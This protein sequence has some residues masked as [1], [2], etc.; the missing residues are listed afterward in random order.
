MSGDLIPI[1]LLAAGASRR[2]GRPKALLPWGKQTLIEYQAARLSALG[3]PVVVVLGCHAGKILPYLRT[4]NVDP[5]P[6]DDWE[7]GMGHSIAHGMKHITLH[8]PEACGVLIILTDQPLI[9]TDHFRF[10]LEA[11]RPGREQLIV[12][13]SE[14]GLEGPPV[15]LDHRY[16]PDL[17]ALT[18]DSGARSI[19]RHY[20]E[21][22]QIIQ[23]RGF[24]D[25]L[26]DLDDYY[27]MHLTLFGYP[28]VN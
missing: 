6:F 10:M 24:M 28:G 13:R 23:V 16:F 18:G 22:K 19:L 4:R 15:L 26:D 11:Y 17:L 21:N 2:M 12:S 27:R 8:Y 5:V 9:E 1:L 20:P 14:E 7:L 3:M 25:D